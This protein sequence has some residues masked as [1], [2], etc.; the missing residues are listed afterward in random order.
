MKVMYE[1]R[2]DKLGSSYD[3]SQ[4]I[5]W[6]SKWHPKAKKEEG[7]KKKTWIFFI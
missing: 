5:Y 3:F 1:L 2:I 7:G 4:F 6:S